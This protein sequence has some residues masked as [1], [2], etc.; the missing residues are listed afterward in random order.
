[1]AHYDYEVEYYE[2]EARQGNTYVDVYTSP[3][4]KEVVE[5]WLADHPGCSRDCVVRIE[6]IENKFENEA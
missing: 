3:N 6:E 2:S 5:Q 4:R 1:M